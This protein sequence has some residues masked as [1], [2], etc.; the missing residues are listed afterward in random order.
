MSEGVRIADR[1]EVI[2]PLGS[3]AFGHTLLARDLRL[4]RQVALKV[5]QPGKEADLKAYEL[6]EREA[7]VL[8]DIRHPAVPAIHASFRAPWNGAEAAF[9]AMEYVE[10]ASLAET[11]A[12]RRHLDT[13]A[14]L[15][16]FVEMLGVLDYLHTRIPPVLHRD[17]KPA[18]LIVRPDG[19]PALVDFGSV[20][21]VFLTPEEGG[22]TVA[23][24][25][26]YMPYEQ[27][28]GQAGP[29]SD[30]YA[31]A[32]TFLHLVTGRA[33]PEFMTGAGRLEVPASLPGGDRFRSVIARMLMPSPAER[34]PSAREARGALIGAASTAAAPTRTD[35]PSRAALVRGSNRLPAALLEPGPR[36]LT[37][38]T[39]ALMKRVVS[40]PLELM[41]PSEKPSQGTDIVSLL[42]IGFFSLITAGIL[43]AWFLSIY[44]TRKRRAR[45]YFAE[46]VV[47]SA[48]IIDMTKED[49]GWGEKLS[50]VRY[51]FEADGGR[52]RGA[53]QVRPVIAERWDAGD[54]IQILY[55]PDE[56]YESIIISTS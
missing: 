46:G 9:L 54:T 2:R 28:M 18:N 41:S 11:I 50:R 15:H 32:A 40:T 55:L 1:F 39:K 49:I 17:I 3:G 19:S 13:D 12:E 30:L 14:V 29:S 6:F 7:T 51:E 36:P 24:T 38:D 23:G 8:R 10:G 25:Y 22:S 47:G 4:G 31:L 16:L 33:P 21:N 27:Y 26:G 56:G 42:L 34:F 43:P 37:G 45:K 20:R 35:E 53:D 52:H 5:L 44:L 48:R